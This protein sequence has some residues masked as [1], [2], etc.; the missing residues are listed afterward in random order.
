[1]EEILTRILEFEPLWA[2]TNEAESLGPQSLD[3]SKLVKPDTTALA[4]GPVS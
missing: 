1:M 3:P 2:D 4:V